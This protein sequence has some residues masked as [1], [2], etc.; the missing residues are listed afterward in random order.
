[1]SDCKLIF[2]VNLSLY[3]LLTKFSMISLNSLD[4]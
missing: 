4:V 3:N 1:M 2:A